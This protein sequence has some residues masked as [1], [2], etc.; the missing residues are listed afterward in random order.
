[1]GLVGCG[2]GEFGVC[3]VV[4][5]VFLEGSVYVVVVLWWMLFEVG[6][7]GWNVYCDVVWW[8]VVV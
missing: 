5:C 4:G 2:V 7:F 6:D 3:F 1:M 8:N